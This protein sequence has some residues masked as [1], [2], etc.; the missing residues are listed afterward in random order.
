MPV[1]ARGLGASEDL[2]DLSA[3]APNHHSS[4]R[5]LR[6]AGDPNKSRDRSPD[7]SQTGPPQADGPKPVGERADHALEDILKSKPLE[8]MQ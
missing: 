3:R 5:I 8:G 1:R 4:G 2:Y 7:L 6:Q